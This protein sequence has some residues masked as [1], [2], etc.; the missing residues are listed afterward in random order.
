[1]IIIYLDAHFKWQMFLIPVIGIV[2]DIS[3]LII[4]HAF[5]DQIRQRGFTGP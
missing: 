1:M 3:D 2:G 5:D 4:T